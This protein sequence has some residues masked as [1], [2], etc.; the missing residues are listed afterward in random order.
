M[1]RASRLPDAHIP[2]QI[3]ADVSHP[4]MDALSGHG[5]CAPAADPPFDLQGF[6]RRNR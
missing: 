1:N 5:Q 2:A 3:T 4:D 6:G